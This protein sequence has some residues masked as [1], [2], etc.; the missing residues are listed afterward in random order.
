MS[1]PVCK[2]G[3]VPASHLTCKRCWWKVP[4]PLRD[5]VWSTWKRRRRNPTKA[6]VAAHEL[7]KLEALTAA[8]L[9]FVGAL[10]ADRQ[11]SE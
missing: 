3:D 5:R 8:E 10:A 1:C 6:N 7:A 4:R 11:V 2:M 9:A